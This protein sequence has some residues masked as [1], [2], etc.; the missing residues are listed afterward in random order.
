MR[1]PKVSWA[2]TV[3]V[4]LLPA[5]TV[6][7]LAVTANLAVAAALTVMELLVPAMALL[8]VSVTVKV[9]GP[10]VLRVTLKLP[11]PL[12]NVVLDGGVANPSVEV[13]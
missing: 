8:A 4:T 11:V 12:D 3:K 9:C 6:V 10:A 2:V 5:V 13:K 7:R 1:L